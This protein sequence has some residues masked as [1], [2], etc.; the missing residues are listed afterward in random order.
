LINRLRG[1]DYARGEVLMPSARRIKM[2]R[3]NLT[4]GPRVL[5]MGTGSG[6]LAKLALEKGAAEVVAADVNPA[7][8]EAARQTVPGARV[9]LSNLF[10]KIEGRFDTIIF[11]APWSE[12][13]IA[14]P[15]HHA[16]FED[17]VTGRFLKDARGHLTE[18]GRVW[19]QYSDASAAN[20]SL[21]LGWIKEHGYA[22]QREWTL[23]DWDLFERKK[24]TICLYKLAPGNV[25]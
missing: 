23:K 14:R 16:I 13:T 5:D 1:Y 21:F 17:G 24:A 25:K 15:F 18:T 9:V 22:I 12:G 10:E 2:F 19:V 3:D 7:A 8:V 11:A 6:V 20:F 4:V